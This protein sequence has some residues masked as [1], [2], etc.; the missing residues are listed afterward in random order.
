[1][2]VVVVVVVEEEEGAVGDYGAHTESPLVPYVLCAA[3]I[4]CQARDLDFSLLQKT[5]DLED[6]SSRDQGIC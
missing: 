1:M 5:F 2:V 4:I 6:S 3:V